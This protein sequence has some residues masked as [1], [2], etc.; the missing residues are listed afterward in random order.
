MFVAFFFCHQIFWLLYNLS[1]Y[2][3]LTQ[4]V[5]F[6]IRHEWKSIKKVAGTIPATFQENMDI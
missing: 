2:A 4:C 1:F 3:Y 6:A 5:L